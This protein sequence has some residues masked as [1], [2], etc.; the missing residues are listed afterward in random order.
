MALSRRQ[1]QARRVERLEAVA[2]PVELPV[3]RDERGEEWRCVGR[4]PNEHTGDDRVTAFTVEPRHRA[5]RPEGTGQ[6]ARHPR[7]RVVGDGRPAPARPRRRPR[8]VPRPARHRA[9]RWRNFGVHAPTAFMCAPF[10]IHS[11]ASTGFC[12]EVQVQM[13]SASATAARALGATWTSILCR[14]D[15]RSAK[16]RALDSVRLHTWTSLISRARRMASRWVLAC[17]PEP[18][19]ARLEASLR[20][21]SR[22]ATPLA[23]A[24]RM[25]VIELASMAANRQ[26]C[27]VSKR[28]TAPWWASNSV[29]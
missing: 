25:A 29:P 27:S 1:S 24:V 5:R 8:T 11:P 28:S 21:S 23:A 3:F 12:A 22:V 14:S 20:A 10:A 13:M 2:R 18:R 16:R 4:R 19:M 9:P 26:P 6:A 7:D 17:T 15:S